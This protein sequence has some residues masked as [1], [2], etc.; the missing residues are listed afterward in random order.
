MINA[1][2]FFCLYANSDGL[3]ANRIE[4]SRD[5]N[6]PLDNYILSKLKSAVSSID[7]NLSSYDTVSACNE[8]NSFFEVLNNWYI[9]RSRQRFW[10]NEHNQDKQDA[11]DV[12]YSCLLYM[13]ESCAAML[14]FTTEHIFQSLVNQDD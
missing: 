5:F 3:K 9:R 14:P 8:F 10:S 13:C 4:Y 7:S 11:Y 12:L 6:N 2:N 1:F